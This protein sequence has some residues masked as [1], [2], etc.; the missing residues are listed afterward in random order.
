MFDIMSRMN[1]IFQE[2]QTAFEQEAVDTGR[3][4]LLLTM[5]TAGGSYF[6][7]KAYETDKV[8]EY[9][10]DGLIYSVLSISRGNIYLN[11]HQRHNIPRLHGRNL[12]W[13]LGWF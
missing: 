4:K 8:A 2:L 6:I 13:F 9:V 12:G 5:A 7:N 10:A 1:S 11:I 3:D